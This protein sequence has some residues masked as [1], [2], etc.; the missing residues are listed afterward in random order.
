ML[1]EKN[2]LYK[3]KLAFHPHQFN[4]VYFVVVKSF[5]ILYFQIQKRV[6][7]FIKDSTKQKYRF[8]T[9]DKVLRAIV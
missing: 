2:L 5:F 3:L 7:E 6:H 1:H 9:M 8:E 4:K